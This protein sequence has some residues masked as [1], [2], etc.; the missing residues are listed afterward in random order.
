[1]PRLEERKAEAVQY[2]MAAVPAALECSPMLL[3]E[4]EEHTSLS[5]SSFERD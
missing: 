5:E 2:N 1:M 3:H 4:E